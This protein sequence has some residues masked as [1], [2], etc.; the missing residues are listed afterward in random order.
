MDAPPFEVV[1]ADNG[2]TDGAI[3]AAL[4][5][6]DGLVL[7]VVDAS[8]RRG[9]THARNRGV[10]EAAADK[11]LLLDQDDAVSDRYVA[12]MAAALDD[13]EAVAAAMDRTR[14]NPD[15]WSAVR[16]LAQCTA[17]PTDPVPWGYGCTL[18]LRRETFEAVGGFDTSLYVAAED[19]DLCLRLA[20][21]G[22]TLTYVPEAVVHY[23]FPHRARS[24]Y[25][26]GRRYGVGGVVLARKHGLALPSAPTIARRTVAAAVGWVRG[27]GTPRGAAFAFVLGRNV[28]YV[29]GALGR[30]PGS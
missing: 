23:R 15:G 1:L 16:D 22:V 28:G 17:L 30:R 27:R 12:V 19:I 25:R 9:Q 13:H 21:L 8:Q 2:S 7:R 20:E 24:L 3:A 26:Q 18:G 11:L 10:A 5:R 29:E 14:L 4:A 6:T